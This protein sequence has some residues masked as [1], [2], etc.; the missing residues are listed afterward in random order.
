MKQN[1]VNARL[2]GLQL[3]NNQS[4]VSHKRFKQMIGY[5]ERK[6]QKASQLYQAKASLNSDMSM[7]KLAAY[8]YDE[9]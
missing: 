5:K 2:E 3:V 6:E 8:Q 4:L 1:E 9:K 7:P